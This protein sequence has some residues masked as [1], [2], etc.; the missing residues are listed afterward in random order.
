M[1]FR[2]SRSRR[3]LFFGFHCR[4]GSQ[5]LMVSYSGTQGPGALVPFLLSVTTGLTQRGP[6]DLQAGGP[7]A[8]QSLFFQLL[9]PVVSG[10]L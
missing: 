5:G 6:W 1:R 4:G 2:R 10:F 7:A 8:R 3:C 9:C